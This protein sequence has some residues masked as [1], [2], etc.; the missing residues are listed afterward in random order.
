MQKKL[1]F[2]RHGQ[3]DWN[4]NEKFH[5]Q[6]DIPLNSTGRAQA[7][8]IVPILKRHRIELILSSDLKR[9]QQTA[10]IIASEIGIPLHEHLDLREADIGEAQGLTREQIIQNFG[11]KLTQEWR[12]VNPQH[13]HARYPGGESGQ[14]II[15]RIHGFLMKEIPKRKETRIAVSTHGGIIRRLMQKLLP[16][17]S[18]SVPI[19]NGI[20][21]LVE[22]DVKNK[23]LK[24]K[25]SI[26]L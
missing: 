12:S 23:I 2:F 24:C 18:H 3:T 6:A 21:Y 25:N 14:E 7:L 5:G 1:Y 11:S 16:E 26:D 19:P 17:L 8:R 20:L 13:L 10:E 22:Y 15:Q 4:K 9:A